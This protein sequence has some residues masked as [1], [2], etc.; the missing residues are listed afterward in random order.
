[1]ALP[2]GLLEAVRNYLD[3]TWT[4]IAGDVK[5]S[6]IIARGIKYIDGVAGSSMDY[7]VEDKPRELL[8]D[9]CR[10]ARSNALDEFQGNYLHELLTLQMTQQVTAYEALVQVSSLTIGE[11]VLNPTFDPAVKL[12]TASTVNDQDIITVATNNP[13]AEISI[14]NDSTAIENGAAATWIVGKNVVTITI[15]NGYAFTTYTVVVTRE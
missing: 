13:L 9:Y 6:G 14:L 12:Y 3:I 10:Y 5:L 7:T 8:F 4:D 1:M 15:T 2:E 11:L